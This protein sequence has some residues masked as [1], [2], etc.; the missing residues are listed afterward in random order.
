[1]AVVTYKSASQQTITAKNKF[2]DNTKLSFGDDDD[3]FIQWN[4]TTLEVKHKA[5]DDLLSVYTQIVTKTTNQ[6]LDSTTLV[7]DTELVI[8]ILMSAGDFVI[9]QIGF[10]AKV[11]STENIKIAVKKGASPAGVG[12]I[13]A[14]LLNTSNVLARLV[15][16]IVAAPTGFSY[17]QQGE[18][19]VVV[20]DFWYS[21]TGAG[22]HTLT[23]Q[24]AKD[25]DLSGQ[26][27][28]VEPTSYI[29]VSPPR[30]A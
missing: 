16:S 17:S 30:G 21:A 2:A 24:W 25:T 15:D 9:G 6:S 11:V 12:E 10:F 19:E 20:I 3:A 18:H 22:T 5:G 28:V 7:D 13:S 8:P 4:G 1:M 26:S 29:R 23:V 27:L 14:V